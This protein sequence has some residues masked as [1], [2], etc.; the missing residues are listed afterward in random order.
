VFPVEN[1]RQTLILVIFQVLKK[2]V[3]NKEKHTL[4]LMTELQDLKGKQEQCERQRDSSMSQLEDALRQLRD[5]T[6][7]VE[8]YN[9]ELK[10]TERQYQDSEKKREEMRCKA[11]ETVKM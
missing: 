10:N 8:R 3:D 1:L 9:D 7:D 2:D 6:R 4:K 11:Q 5:V